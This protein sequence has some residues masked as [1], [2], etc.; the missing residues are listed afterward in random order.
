MAEFITNIDFEILYW[1]QENLRCAFLDGFAWVLSTCF[2]AGLLWI[3]LCI[4]LFIFRKTRP[5]SVAVTIAI[6]LTFLIGELALKNTVCRPRPCL[7]DPSVSLAV[8][9]PNSYSF[10]SGHTGSSFAAAT[11]LFCFSKKWGIPCLAVATIVGLSR[12]YL[13][14]HY[15]TDV[16][17]GVLLGTFAAVVTFLVMK[18][19]GLDKRLENPLLKKRIIKKKA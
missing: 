2:E 13:F 11:A 12:M 10:P 19:Y 6:V 7:I 16:L 3:V 9:V 1:M 14:V 5:L 15:P 8:P 4:A 18:K 17:V